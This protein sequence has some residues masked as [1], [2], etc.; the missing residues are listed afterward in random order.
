MPIDRSIDRSH[1]GGGG[2]VAQQ[3][4]A[5][6]IFL[7]QAHPDNVPNAFIARQQPCMVGRGL[8]GGR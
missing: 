7:I 1:G 5:A 6:L 4:I 2:G 3:R 8:V